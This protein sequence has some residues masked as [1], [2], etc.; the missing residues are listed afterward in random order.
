LHLETAE[1]LFLDPQKNDHVFKGL[2]GY[3]EELE[4]NLKQAG[5]ADP[6]FIY[7]QVVSMGECLSSFLLFSYLKYQELDFTFLEAASLI[8]TDDNWREGEVDF[9]E[10]SKIIQE[11]LMP[12]L[13][14][15]NVLTQGFLGGTSDG[16]RTTLGREG[17]D[18]SAAL[19][20]YFID[21]ETV[22]I[23]KDVSGVLSADPKWKPDAVLL[24]ELS[25]QEAAELTYYGATVIHPKTI[26]PLARKK[27]PLQ[28][29]SFL[30]P[31][32]PGTLIG[33]DFKK[34]HRESWIKKDGQ[35]LVSISSRDFSFM[36]EKNIQEVLQAF[37]NAG[38]KMQMLQVSATSISIVTDDEQNRL[39]KAFQKIAPG[40]VLL[41]NRDLTLI[42]IQ[43]PGDSAINY[44]LESRRPILVQKTRS[45]IQ[46]LFASV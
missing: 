30:H 34:Q 20:A 22:T 46:M 29:R 37:S 15:G 1:E 4:S 21:A 42:T 2:R 36:E 35:V 11:H 25:Y 27:I 6:C 32:E 28:V 43:N 10:S 38:L 7:D 13:R 41:F 24:P 40:Y 18:Y 5:H 14:Q 23:W 16:L 26:R 44:Q 8:R 45:T 33:P 17:S 39:D 12:L 9:A 19:L 31:G 3:F